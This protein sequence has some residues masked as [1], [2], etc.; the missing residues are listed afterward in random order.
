MHGN[1][2][3]LPHNFIKVDNLCI[4][5]QNSWSQSVCYLEV[6]LLQYACYNLAM[7]VLYACLFT[8]NLVM[9]YGSSRGL[10]TYG[11]AVDNDSK[12]DDHM[13]DFDSLNL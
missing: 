5:V 10:G 12:C 11:T 2:T 7:H 13:L 9:A 1:T 8:R 6:P 3:I 4:L